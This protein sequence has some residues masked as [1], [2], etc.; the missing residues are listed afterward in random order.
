MLDFTLTE[1]DVRSAIRSLPAPDTCKRIA[2]LRLAR[3]VDDA[4]L[5]AGDRFVAKQQVVFRR[6]LSRRHLCLSRTARDR[7]QRSGA[8]RPDVQRRAFAAR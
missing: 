4:G 1:P 7:R 5:E 8:L 2:R 6:G 3:N